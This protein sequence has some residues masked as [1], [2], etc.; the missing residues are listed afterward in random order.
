MRV[1]VPIPS[2]HELQE[3]LSLVLA[4]VA[5]HLPEHQHV[6]VTRTQVAAILRLA[7]KQ[8]DVDVG[9]ARHEDL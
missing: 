5:E 7:A 6:L 8:R 3:L 1:C 2:P 9:I 4:H